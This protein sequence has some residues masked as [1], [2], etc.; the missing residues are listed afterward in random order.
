LHF[1]YP[2]HLSCWKARL[3]KFVTAG[4]NGPPTQCFIRGYNL[5]GLTRG[6]E[7]F[8][9]AISD[10]LKTQ[11]FQNFPALCQPW[12]LFVGVGF[13]K[14]IKLAPWLTKFWYLHKH[15]MQVLHWR[16]SLSTA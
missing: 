5:K 12:W 13:S 15:T 10:D 3:N 4:G 11:N 2:I 16:F 6:R 9:N 8:E 7:H 1:P 14:F